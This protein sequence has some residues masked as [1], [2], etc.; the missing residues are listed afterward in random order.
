MVE[1]DY[2]GAR[3]GFS[4]PNPPIK[5]CC[6]R[7]IGECNIA[8]LFLQPHFLKGKTLEV[9]LEWGWGSWGIKVCFMR[10]LEGYTVPV[11]F[12]LI[13]FN[14]HFPRGIRWYWK[15]EGQPVSSESK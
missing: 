6:C 3:L 11:G 13:V 10:L 8:L 5:D 7:R 9:G 2:S 15:R 14:L 4:G 1:G 12:N